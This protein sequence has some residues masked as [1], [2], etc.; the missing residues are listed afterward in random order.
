MK[1]FKL[2]FMLAKT[3]TMAVDGAVVRP[4]S[5]AGRSP[6]VLPILGSSL[7]P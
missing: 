5:A 6:A 3:R 2:E 4:P 7:K 1:K